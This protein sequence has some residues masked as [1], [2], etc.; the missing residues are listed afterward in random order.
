MAPAPSARHR[1]PAFAALASFALSAGLVALAAQPPEE[2]EANPK[3]ARKQVPEEE[4]KGGAKKKI[5]VVDPDGPGPKAGGGN[6]PDVQLDEVVKAAETA[7]PALKEVLRRYAVP[8]DRFTDAKGQASRIKPLPLFRTDRFPPQFGVV[9]VDAA[10]KVIA[11]TRTV[12]AAEVKQ[13]EHFEELVLAEADKLAKDTSAG[14][15]TPDARFGA[16]ETLLAAAARYHDFAKAKNIRKGEL[17]NP[18]RP[19][20]AEKLKDTRVVRLRRA[21]AG[22]NWA[23]ALEAG[24]TLMREYPKDA[25]GVGAEVGKARVAGAEAFMRSGSHAD[26]VRARELL[27]N[28][29]TTFPGA[30][31]DAAKKIRKDL[32]A[33]ADR[34][35]AQALAAKSTGGGVDARDYA[36]RAADLDRNAAGLREL[37]QQLG[38][39]AA[40]LYVGA[41][42]FP[43]RMSPATARTDSERQVVELLFSGLY[44]EVPDKAGGVRYRP[45]AA[46]TPALVVP[47]G[48]D[49]L[50]RTAQKTTADPEG[51]DTADV[52]ATVKLLRGRPD[53]WAAAPLPWLDDLP[54]PSGGAG[55]RVGFRHAHPDPRALLTFKL[56][57]G[58][59]LTAGGKALDDPDFAAAPKFGTGPYRIHRMPDS[60][61]AGPRE[62]VFTPNPAYGQG[63]D[64]AGQPFIKEVQVVDLGRLADP[65]DEFKRGRLHV[66]PDLTPAEME[67]VRK[68]E[69]TEFGGKA[70]VVTA[71]T[72]RRVH[73]LA[74]NLRTPALRS[75][76]LR[77][78]LNLVLDRDPIV[79]EVYRF[80]TAENRVYGRAMTGPFPPYSW[81]TVK[82]RSNEPV[83]LYNRPLGV[84]KLKEYLAAPGAKASFRLSYPA[85]D[86]LAAAACDK[87][88][89]QVAALGLTTP[90]GQAFALKPDP[91]PR[92]ELLKQVEE[93]HRY[94]F[95]YVPLEYPDDWY[96]FG[97]A[98]FLDPK[99]AAR[100]GR[101]WTG[102]GDPATGPGA[103][104]QVLMGELSGLLTHR[105]FEKQLLPRAHRIHNQ[106]NQ[107]VPFIPL[108]HLDR[109]ML[110]HTGLKV[111]LDDGP[112]PAPATLLNQSTLFQNVARW[113]LE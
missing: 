77:Q 10:G 55:V 19:L 60:A 30:G 68:G 37:Q 95:A 2:E 59:W 35:V 76:A 46:Q 72:N 26:K 50:L 23:A 96:P 113:R 34:L 12:T 75:K 104:D 74:V 33:E 103:E 65:L 32:S 7:P 16:A 24:D 69:R 110:V 54:A 85:D 67:R 53:S 63:R 100:G 106:F 89:K 58:R 57:P 31:G 43:E 86:P 48:R 91:L 90:D 13:I 18:V 93:E 78:G 25:A 14:A 81:A 51:F 80:A 73:V 94:D 41:R 47:N 56:L 21:T 97:L 64:R 112:D 39:G 71:Q 36:S 87:L 40:V 5:E 42:S 27:D 88:A 99:A 70:K 84:E 6:T 108:W 45:A 22:A 44:E 107:V 20:L 109:H 38:T 79:R 11:E 61:S 102:F 66:L 8:A 4:G 52:V 98:A 62:L 101:N 9:E 1:F 83:S 111:Y 17:W 49:V 15:V 3:A 82:D 29:D 28:L 92:R 105:D